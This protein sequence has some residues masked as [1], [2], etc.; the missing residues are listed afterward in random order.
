MSLTS[1]R[2]TNIFHVFSRISEVFINIHENANEITAIYVHDARKY[3]KCYQ[4]WKST[5][6]NN[7]GFDLL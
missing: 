5:M 1:K 6:P 2:N 7:D 3:A 4:W